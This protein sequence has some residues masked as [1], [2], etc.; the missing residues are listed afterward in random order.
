MVAFEK[1]SPS[2]DRRAVTFSTGAPAPQVL[3]GRGKGWKGKD[4]AAKPAAS[5]FYQNEYLVYDE[6][7]V[8]LR[9][10]VKVKL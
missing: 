8:R 2:I 10:I 1:S 3:V 6:A 4:A 5:S 7:Q 9:Y